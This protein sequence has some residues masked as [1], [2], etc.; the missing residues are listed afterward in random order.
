MKPSILFLLSLTIACTNDKK[1]EQGEAPDTNTD[2]DDTALVVDCEATMTSTPSMELPVSNWFYRDAIEL[3]FS[4][5]NL[6]IAVSATDGAGNSI[7]VGY[8]WN[9]SRERAYIVPD[10]GVW[11]GDTDYTITVDYCGTSSTV[12]FGTSKYGKAL[13]VTPEQLVGRTYNIDLTAA[14]YTEPPGI[15][16]LLGQNIDQPLLFGIDSATETRLDFIAA[17]GE[18]DNFGA[19][20]QITG[21]WSFPNA[22]FSTTPYFEAFS[23]FLAIDYGSISIPIHNFAISGT[24]SADG[25]TIGQANFSGL[26]DTRE[27]GP[28]LSSSFG[29]DAICNMLIAAGSQ[30]EVC[31]G[32]TSGNAFCA[33]LAGSI[34]EVQIIPNLTLV[35]M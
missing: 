5:M 28:A 32:D 1:P 8:T 18:Y 33:F 19:V 16:T 21:L 12:E 23:D 9:D 13:E 26:G 7:A 22:D 10:T 27:L 31:P 2:T 17:L 24:F 11:D 35:E 29:E 4:E 14:T 20:T 15:G 30:C 34:E 3:T 6:A 25:N